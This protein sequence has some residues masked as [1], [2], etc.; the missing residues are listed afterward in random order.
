MMRPFSELLTA[1]AERIEHAVASPEAGLA[2][3]VSQ[4]DLEVP[5]VALIG[6]GGE[7]TASLPRGRLATGFDPL[8]GKVSARF[9]VRPR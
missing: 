3:R 8:L 9:E 7:L 1:L 4:L 5:V 2:L 6:P